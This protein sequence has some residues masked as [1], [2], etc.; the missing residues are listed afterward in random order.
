MN[1]LGIV[2]PDRD[3]RFGNDV[4]IVDC[5]SGE[6]EALT[7]NQKSKCDQTGLRCLTLPIF[8]Y[9]QGKYPKS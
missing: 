6:F 1:K 3:L 7:S 2:I 8:S 4:G 9:S 5:L